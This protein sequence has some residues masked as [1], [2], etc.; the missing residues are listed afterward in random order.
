MWTCNDSRRDLHKLCRIPRNCQCKASSRVP[1]TFASFSG[2]LV[3]FWFCTDTPG[4]HKWLGP[5]PRLRN[6]DC[7][8]TRNCRLGPCGLLCQVTIICG[9][10]CGFA[11]ASSAWG[12]CSVGPFTDLA[13]SVFGEMSMN[14]M[15]TQILT[16]LCSKLHRGFMRRT[17]VRAS[18]QWNFIIHQ[19][20]PEFLQP[21]RDLRITTR[22]TPFHRGFLFIGFWVFV[23][24]GF[25]QV[26]PFYHQPI[27]TLALERCP[28]QVHLPF[29][30]PEFPLL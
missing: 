7:F 29:L 14:I 19:I 11:I 12:P 21:S 25:R 20:F 6:D 10:R 22:V 13:I 9:S 27:Q 8:E 18:L 15:F 24:L 3:K 28:C 2:F 5:A 4:S 30:A 23:G 1:R 17:G 26:S 16:S